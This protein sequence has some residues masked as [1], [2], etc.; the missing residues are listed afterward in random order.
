M[1]PDAVTPVLVDPSTA[2]LLDLRGWDALLRQAR[3]ANL[4]ARIARDVEQLGALDKV[5]AAPRAHLI[6]SLTLAARQRITVRA[7]V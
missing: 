2:P 5:P 1:K 6:A 4:L 7:E 3:H